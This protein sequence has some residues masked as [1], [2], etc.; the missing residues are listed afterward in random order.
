[1]PDSDSTELDWEDIRYFVA[2]ARYGTLSEI[3]LALKTCLGPPAR[4]SGSVRTLVFDEVDAGIGGGV[5]ESRLARDR[6]RW[7]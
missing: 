6:R 2:L 3:A 7:P 4:G 1:M 5:A